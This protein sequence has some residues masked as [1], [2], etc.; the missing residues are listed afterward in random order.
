M[1][2]F[3]IVGAFAYLPL[4]KALTYKLTVSGLSILDSNDNPVILRGVMN[5]LLVSESGGFPVANIVSHIQVLASEGCNYYR[6]ANIPWSQMLTSDNTVS[7]V[8]GDYSATWLAYID[9]IASAC[10]TYH[11]YF[12]IDYEGIAFAASYGFSVPS[13][14]T[15]TYGL[16]SSMSN[17]EIQFFNTGNSAY[18]VARTAFVNTEEFFIN[19]YSSNPF[20][21]VASW[22]EPYNTNTIF[23]ANDNSTS[24]TFLTTQSGRYAAWANAFVTTVDSA[25]GYN[26]VFVIDDPWVNDFY[27]T[28]KGDRKSVV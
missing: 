16:T 9:A 1:L 27:T 5:N 28:T 15:G 21:I 23:N 22:C 7:N 14:L 2:V 4:T 24:G 19:R 20:Y 10:A 26:G 18:N 13:F 17:F 12:S 8:A 11:V 6:I 25:T 3:F